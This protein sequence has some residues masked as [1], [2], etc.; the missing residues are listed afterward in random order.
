MR[1]GLGSNDS[2]YIIAINQVSYSW[3]GKLIEENVLVNFPLVMFTN[4]THLSRKNLQKSKPQFSEDHPTN[5][6]ALQVN[7]GH[8]NIVHYSYVCE[9]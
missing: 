9:N 4:L 8:S 1:E 3:Q 7:K 2:D 5:K 6:L